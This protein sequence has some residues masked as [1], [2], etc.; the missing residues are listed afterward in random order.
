MMKKGIEKW[1]DPILLV[2]LFASILISVGMV[3]FGN[4]PI[5]SFIV[6]LLSTI[7]T[8]LIDLIARMGR[9]EGNLI[10]TLKFAHNLMSTPIRYDL[11]ALARDY[12]EIERYDFDLYRKIASDSISQC[13]RR[14]QE[15]ASGAV[16][17]P[18]NSVYFYNIEGIK[19]A[20]E[21]IKVTHLSSPNYWLS[22]AGKRFLEA[23]RDAFKR[24]VT[25]VMVFAASDDQSENSRA[26]LDLLRKSRVKVSTAKPKRIDQEFMIIDDKILL[27]YEYDK[28]ENTWKTW[29]IL[30]ADEVR[31]A[32]NSF[33][34]YLDI[35]EPY[36]QE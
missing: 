32:V 18:D 21:T 4:D 8:L 23:S 19:Q 10:E 6:G 34:R 14:F 15:I 20:R 3:I 31:K 26:V 2:G 12:K 24:R 29:I 1:L 16:V 36:L 27:R 30:D 5:N 25:T 13:K 33:G 7:I 22:D 28:N 11:E 35:A 9:T 17:I